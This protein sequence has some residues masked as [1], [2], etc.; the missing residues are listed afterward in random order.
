[1]PKTQY[2]TDFW[3]FQTV[4]CFK[5]VLEFILWQLVIIMK[6][7]SATATQIIKLSGFY[8]SRIKQNLFVDKIQQ[9][10]PSIPGQIGTREKKERER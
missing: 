3:L 7:P 8:R 6:T 1:M 2:G 5:F 9:L 4:F 10:V